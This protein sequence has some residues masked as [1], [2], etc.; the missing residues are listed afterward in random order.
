VTVLATEATPVA[1]VSRAEG[2]RRLAEAE[3]AYAAADRLDVPALDAAMGRIQSAQAM[4]AA[5]P[6]G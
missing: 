4:L 2:E 6:G 1:D 5:A 3:A